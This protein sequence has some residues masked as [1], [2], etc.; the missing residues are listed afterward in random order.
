M[1]KVTF[2]AE[3][4]TK[5]TVRFTE[6]LEGKLTN[7]VIGT[8]YI[9]KETLKAKGWSDGDDITL[10]LEIAGKPG[11]TEGRTTAAAKAAASKTTSKSTAKATSKKTTAKKSAKAAK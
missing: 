2:T 1:C 10:D 7:P 5:N 3:K 9:P 6:V 11:Q 8:V 4:A